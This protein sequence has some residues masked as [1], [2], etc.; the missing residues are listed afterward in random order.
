VTRLD[1]E[2]VDLIAQR[3]LALLRSG[4]EASPARLVDATTLARALGVTR[5]W[6][7]AHAQELRAVRLGGARG[8]LRFDLDL[9]RQLLQAEVPTPTRTPRRSG[10][11][12]TD[13]AADLLPIDP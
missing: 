1:P 7:Y 12:V 13:S 3:V 8:R 11:K 5:A 6:V 4:D 9:V 2:D 10:T